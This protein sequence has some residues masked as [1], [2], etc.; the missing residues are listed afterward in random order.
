MRV[1][2][3]HSW[4]ATIPE[5]KEIQLR[6]AGEVSMANK[7]GS[8]R[9]IA[10]V[11]ISVRKGDPM[12]TGAVVVVGFPELAPVEVQ[13]VRQEIPFPYVPGLLS[14]REAPLILAGFEQLSSEPDLVLVDG[15]GMA[16]PRRLGLACHLGLFLD[17]PAIGCAKS[18]L[19]GVHEPV[20]TERG[21]FAELRDGD[22]VIGAALCTKERTK[23]IYVS[24]GH[25]VDL[26]HAIKWALEC[27]RGYKNPE[28]LRLAH[29][30]AGGRLVGS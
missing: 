20:V 8:P 30:A 10:G 24:I 23:P 16:H 14:F 7:V 9:L 28:P 6:L 13:V 17:L 18:R 19:F 29:L 4:K 1:R 21:D 15:Q 2:E 22:E 11:D 3:L 25:K 5:A 27:C 12:G 26:P